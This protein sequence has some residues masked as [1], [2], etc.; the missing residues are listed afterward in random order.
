[1]WVDKYIGKKWTQEQDCG[2]W[3][4][5]IQKEQFGRDM[6][7]ICNI[8]A[9]PRKFIRQA[10]HILRRVKEKA[11]DIGW[12]AT[13]SPIEGDAALLAMRTHIHHIGVVI[14]I[15][16]QLQ[17]LHAPDEGSGVMLSSKKNLRENLMRIEGFYTYGN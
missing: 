11:N 2:Y 5:K 8:P 17:I 3:F 7:A 13:C 10:M 1:M 6:P 14:Y 16:G 15:D 4:R 12:H 9:E